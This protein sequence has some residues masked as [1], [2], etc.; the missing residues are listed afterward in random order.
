M[1][2]GNPNDLHERE[3]AVLRL[4]LRGCDVKA[5]ARELQISSN[6]VN[7]R[8]R[9]VRKKLGVTS[10]REAARL[11]AASESGQDKFSVHKKSGVAIPPID[12]ASEMQPSKR[13]QEE[14]DFEHVV[15]REKQA[16]FF[17][18]S[19]A[20]EIGSVEKSNSWL[21]QPLPVRKSGGLRNEL[22]KQER[23]YAVV[24]LSIKIT[25]AFALLCLIS[26]LLEKFVS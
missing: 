21:S 20:V 9:D 3:K 11:L 25:A 2:R 23:I 14:S 1:D 12:D 5:A 15:F 8:L 16:A 13:A 4:L 17:S 7:E 10:S 19:S 26:I 22:S 24:D 18:A 6:V